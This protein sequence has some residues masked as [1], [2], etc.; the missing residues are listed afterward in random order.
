MSSFT[1]NITIK[2]L[3]LF[4]WLVMEQEEAW[5]LSV[6]LLQIVQKNVTI[7]AASVKEAAFLS[8]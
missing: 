1:I 8:S 3:K 5:N 2:Y 7:E 6:V 4:G